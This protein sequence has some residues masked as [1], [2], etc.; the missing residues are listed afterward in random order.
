MIRI[1]S[2]TQ[3]AR[4][5]TGLL[6]YESVRLMTSRADFPPPNRKSTRHHLETT[7]HPVAEVVHPSMAKAGPVRP[8]HRDI[9][10]APSFEER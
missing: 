4:L 7:G 1:P 10:V 2:D 5:I 9:R 6:S 8:N 3:A